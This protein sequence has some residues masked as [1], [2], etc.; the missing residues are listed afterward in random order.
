[1][2]SKGKHYGIE[3]TK[4]ELNRLFAKKYDQIDLEDGFECM[5]PHYHSSWNVAEKEKCQFYLLAGKK[6]EQRVP[7]IPCLQSNGQSGSWPLTN[8]NSTTC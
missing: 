2:H 7:P 5:S 8:T 4:G 1:M 3:T 6:T